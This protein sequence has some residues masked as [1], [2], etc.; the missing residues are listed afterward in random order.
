MDFAVSGL[1]F[2]EKVLEEAR[3]LLANPRAFQRPAQ[4]PQEDSLRYL[5]SLEN[6]LKQPLSRRNYAPR[7][8]IFDEEVDVVKEAS[9]Q[10]RDSSGNWV[11]STFQLM[12]DGKL[13][14]VKSQ[15]S[16]EYEFTYAECVL[17]RLEDLNKGLDCTLI[18]QNLESIE[19][20]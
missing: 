11:N 4:I 2:G 17:R 13:K 15:Q 10:I 3:R 19:M 18:E 9:V 14:V 5:E 8:G 20:D 16:S 6:K 1:L 12:A 7:G